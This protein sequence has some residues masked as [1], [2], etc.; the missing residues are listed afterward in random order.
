METWNSNKQFSEILLKNKELNKLLSN[1][2]IKKIID[3]SNK[4]KNI[5]W[6]YKNKIK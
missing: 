4:L 3:N 1:N 6:I 2:D 5:K